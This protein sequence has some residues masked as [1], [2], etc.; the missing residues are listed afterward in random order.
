MVRHGLAIVF[1]STLTDYNKYLGWPAIAKTWK[2]QLETFAG[3]GFRAV[4]PDMP[5]RRR[6][7][8]S[9]KELIG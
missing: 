2:H 5:G 7:A 9:R 6:A 1:L 3:L 4:A 8:T